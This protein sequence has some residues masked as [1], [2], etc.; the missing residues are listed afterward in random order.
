MQSRL[1]ISMKGEFD[2]NLGCV[3]HIVTY[4]D[5]VVIINIP[6]KNQQY[7]FLISAERIV[8]VRQIVDY[9][10]HSIGEYSIFSE[11]HTGQPNV[12]ETKKVIQ[13]T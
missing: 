12:K 1:E 7:N 8:D 11:K 9:V 2:E 6:L 4:R 3:N 5:N 10:T 13:S